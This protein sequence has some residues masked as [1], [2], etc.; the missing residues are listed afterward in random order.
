ML[1][2]SDIRQAFVDSISRNPKGYRYLHTRDFVCA[3]QRKGIH[4]SGNEANAW[5]ERYQTYF[6]DKTTDDSENKLWML[7]N[8]GIVL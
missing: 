2:Q 4:F 7:R 3:L 6:V 5:I 1:R 8:M